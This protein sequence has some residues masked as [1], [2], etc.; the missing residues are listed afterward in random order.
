MLARELKKTHAE[1]MS[2]MS[3]RELLWWRAYFNDEAR[4][5]HGTFDRHVDAVLAALRAGDP[6]P[7][8]PAGGRWSIAPSQL[9]SLPGTGRFVAEVGVGIVH[10]ELPAPER[11][12]EPAVTELHRRIKERFDPSGRLNPGV[13]VLAVA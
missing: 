1:L 12:I 13:D 11:S 10:H 7:V 2:G 3:A 5:F 8:F 4:N 9:G 6:P